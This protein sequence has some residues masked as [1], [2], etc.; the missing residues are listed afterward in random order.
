MP[1]KSHNMQRRLE[2]S[3]L[4]NYLFL[5]FVLTKD[6]FAIVL[7][8]DFLNTAN[9][10]LLL[11]SVAVAITANRNYL[12]MIFV[13]P[14]LFWFLWAVYAF[15]VWS[16]IGIQSEGK[17]VNVALISFV[18]PI[19]TMCIVCYEGKKDL[20]RTTLVI[21]VALSAYVIAGLLFQDNS[22][23][24]RH[25]AAERG[26][27]QL[28]NT[29]S[30]K[31][32]VLTFVALFAFVKEWIGKKW[33]ILLALLSL[34]A[35]LYVAT[36]KAFV[37]WIIIMG[38][39]LLSRFRFNKPLDWLK[40]LVLLLAALFVYNYLMEHTYL[41]VR[42]KET[43]EQGM[44]KNETD[45][46]AL[47]YLGDRAMQYVWAW[48]EFLKHPLTGIGI[49][50]YQ[51]VTGSYYR[52][53]SEYMVQLCEC[54]LIGATLYF[55]FVLGL[56]KTLLKSRS[57]GDNRLLF[58]CLGGIL[59]VLFIN[60]TAWTYEGCH[61]FAM[62]GIILALCSPV[63]VKSPDPYVHRSSILNSPWVQLPVPRL[64][65]VFALRHVGFVS[66]E[67]VILC[68]R[69]V[70]MGVSRFVRGVGLAIVGFGSWCWRIPLG[71]YRAVVW[72]VRGVG[73]AIVGLG[74]GFVR[75]VT[76]VFRA[77]RRFVRGIGGSIV[78]LGTGIGRTVTVSYRAVVRLVCGVGSAIVG[79]GTSLRRI[80]SGASGA[81]CRFVQKFSILNFHFSIKRSVIYALASVVALAVVGWGIWFG[82][83]HFDFQFP[84]NVSRTP[85]NSQPSPQVAEASIDTTQVPE[86][87]YEDELDY[88][89]VVED[90]TGMLLCAVPQSWMKGFDLVISWRCTTED[91]CFQIRPVGTER[92]TT[93]HYNDPNKSSDILPF[94]LQK[95]FLA[96]G[97]T[98]EWRLFARFPDNTT[99]VKIGETVIMD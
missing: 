97:K 27:H 85:A 42:M 91:V 8:A 41:G 71:A 78:G 72:L 12:R 36:R 80:A 7:K 15:L 40:L 11:L 57:R 54:G 55:L 3:T 24:N 17:T 82:V 19:I 75:A 59:A 1:I 45:V 28:G 51:V 10:L 35:I 26:G 6:F 48:E 14:I 53:H 95:E 84:S 76:G 70:A 46:E 52:I 73:S 88:S 86:D 21:L 79:F 33:F 63:D 31:A 22:A 4:V 62:Y 60:F 68:V 96:K 37:G 32:C 61:Y 67:R 93:L 2:V 30:L 44:E 92:W 87:T 64:R 43:V 77:A 74:T 13:K 34:V 9:I 94:T 81:L 90:N 56:F 83:S 99:V 65:I 98:L 50:N 49:R 23:I 89:T 47:N 66:A 18:Y 20:R 16:V 5:V 58:A 29:L 25:W 69:Y 39:S 38:V